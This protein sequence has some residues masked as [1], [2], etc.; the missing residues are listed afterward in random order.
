MDLDKSI[1]ERKS[2]RHYSEK[3][4]DWKDIIECIDAARYAPMAGNIFPLRF[5]IVSD[6]DKIKK[7]SE[8]SQ[9]EFVG[10]AKYIVVV[11]TDPS[12]V[13]N[14]YPDFA[15]KFCR[16]QAGAAVENFLLK[17]TEKKLETCWIGYFVEDLIKTALNIP[18]KIVVEAIFP[19]GLQ[20]KK[21][22]TERNKKRK[23]DMDRI[24]YFDKW[25][26]DS[27]KKTESIEV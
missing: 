25:K 20:T 22:G 1:Q 24:L 3:K 16:Q 4:P 9:Q 27:M 26:Q 13:K 11:C 23:I 7:L 19:I 5:I 8:A 17:L 15:E 6:K 2:V 18:D 12:L 10:T 21:V 14:A